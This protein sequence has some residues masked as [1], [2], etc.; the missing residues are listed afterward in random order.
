MY[1][2]LQQLAA[3]FSTTVSGVRQILCA[4]Y[5]ISALDLLNLNSESLSW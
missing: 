1:P 3:K 4:G 2:I 5:V